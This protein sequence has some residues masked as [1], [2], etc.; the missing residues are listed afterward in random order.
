MGIKEKRLADGYE[1]LG[2]TP[3][4]VAAVPKISHLLESISK[5][6]QKKILNYILGSDAD[7]SRRFLEVYSSVPPSN[8]KVLPFEAF[9]V[10][11][12]VSTK[13]M[14]EVI[15]GTVFEQSD[16]E[17]AMLVAIA[18]P[19]IVKDTIKRAKTKFGSAEKK[20]LHQ[21]RGLVPVPK[22]NVTFIRDQKNTLIDN[23]DQRQIANVQM[24]PLDERVNRI[25]D[26]FNEA[27]AS[28]MKALPVPVEV[29]VQDDEDE[30]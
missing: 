24:V 29:T 23:R 11:A 28:A 25:S 6:W 10:A 12:K 21:S 13:R 16:S 17:S 14:W 15:Q 7:E 30:E 1:R 27:R 20:M 18:H 9:C 4:E 26:R 19:D 5:P 3:E 22:N 8:R 2:I